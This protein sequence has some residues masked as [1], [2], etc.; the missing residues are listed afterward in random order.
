M[1]RFEIIDGRCVIPHGVT[2]ILEEEFAD[3]QELK[4]IVIPDTVVKIGMGAFMECHSLQSV[5]IPRSVTKIPHCAF[6]LVH[7]T[8]G[9]IHSGQYQGNRP[10]GFRGLRQAQVSHYT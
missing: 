9:G 6:F 10:A 5:T 3:C 1:A 4:E 7:I 2:E 8:Q